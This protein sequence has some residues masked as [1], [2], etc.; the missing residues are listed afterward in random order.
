MRSLVSITLSLKYEILNERILNSNL[1]RQIRMLRIN[2]V[3][4][5][6]QSELFKSFT[7]LKDVDFQL[8]NIREFFHS[9]TAWMSHLNSGKSFF[10]LS[11]VDAKSIKLNNFFLRFIYLKEMTS[12]DP[13]Y[14][15]PNEDICLFA[16]FPHQQLVFPILV[17]GKILE[18]TCTLKWLEMHSRVYKSLINYT[19]DYTSFYESQFATSKLSSYLFCSKNESNECDFETKFNNCQVLRANDSRFKVKKFLVNFTKGGA[20]IKKIKFFSLG[21]C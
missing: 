21:N 18:C 3:L 15:Y 16:N 12:F 20:F 7:H 17:P 5:G 8:N 2:G 1:F 9:G 19:K 11:R 4:N 10:N 14:E 13:L 6:I